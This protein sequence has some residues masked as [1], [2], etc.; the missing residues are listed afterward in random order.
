[1]QAAYL[2]DDLREYVEAVRQRVC[3]VCSEKP[4]GGPPCLPLG[5]HCGIELHLDKVVDIVQRVHSENLD[6][7]GET[8]HRE[9]CTFCPNREAYAECPC[10]MESLL[11]LAV[12]AIEEVEAR[13]RSADTG[14]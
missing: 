1:M 6:P 9:V 12:E 3:S 11:E 14:S 5:K 2:R 13:K 4:P 8:L 7:Y 10:P